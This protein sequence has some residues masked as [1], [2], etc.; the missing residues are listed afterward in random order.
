[1]KGYSFKIGDTFTHFCAKDTELFK[2]LDKAG[3][4]NYKVPVLGPENWADVSDTGKYPYWGVQGLF[5][6]VVE[7]EIKQIEK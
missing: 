1:M 6:E 2:I 4:I 5:G 3:F 7:V